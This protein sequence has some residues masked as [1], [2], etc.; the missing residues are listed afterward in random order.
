[1]SAQQPNRL[2]G[3]IRTVIRLSRIAQQVCE[4]AGITLPQYRAMNKIAHLR[5]R[6]HEIATATAVSRPAVTAL[7]AGLENAGLMKRAVV[8]AD[9]RGFYFVATAKGRK[10]LAEVERNLVH[11]FAEIL[12]DSADELRSLSTTGAIEEALDKQNEREFG[13]PK[14]LLLADPPR[15][16]RRRARPLS[17]STAG[18]VRARGTFRRNR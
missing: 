8:D 9:K 18:S 7:M 3:A 1:M 10:V 2:L 12:G 4:Q 11:R 13:S 15:L 14:G 5:R 17:L 6:A 16:S